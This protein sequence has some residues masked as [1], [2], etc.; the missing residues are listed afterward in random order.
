MDGV[1]NPFQMFSKLKSSN[2]QTPDATQQTQALE[3]CGMLITDMIS[4]AKTLKVEGLCSVIIAMWGLVIF[5]MILSV[6]VV[7]LST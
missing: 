3:V 1:L 2:V 5:V 4:H 7:P 6:Y